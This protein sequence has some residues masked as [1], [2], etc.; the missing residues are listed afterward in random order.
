MAIVGFIVL[1][2][3]SGAVTVSAGACFIFTMNTPSHNLAR[4]VTALFA[5]GGCV[6]LYFVLVNA[7]FNI[8]IS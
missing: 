2:L 1:L 4:V 3:G 5:I 7:P 8:S 6:G